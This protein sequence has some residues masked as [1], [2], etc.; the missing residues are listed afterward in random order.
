MRKSLCAP[1][2]RMALSLVELGILLL[3][4]RV[5]ISLSL[6]WQNRLTELLHNNPDTLATA[7]VYAMRHSSMIEASFFCAY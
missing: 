1:P 5:W 7:F 6:C 2:S 4:F 3:G